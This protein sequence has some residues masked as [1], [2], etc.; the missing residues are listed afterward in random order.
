MEEEMGM[1]LDQ[2]RE[3]RQAGEINLHGTSGD[4]DLSLGPDGRDTVTDHHDH[5]PTVQAGSL[6]I[7]YTFRTEDFGLLGLPGPSSTDLPSETGVQGIGFMVFGVTRD[8]RILTGDVPDHCRGKGGE[9]KKRDSNT[10]VQKG[11]LRKAAAW[12]ASVCKKAAFR[13][14]AAWIAPA[15]RAAFRKRAAWIAPPRRAA[16]RERAARNAPVCKKAAF[17]KSAVL[18]TTDGRTAIGQSVEYHHGSFRDQGWSG[19]GPES[20][21]ESWKAPPQ[22]FRK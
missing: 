7:E 4:L 1:P 10:V 13:K 12:N 16:F 2:P 22:P 9:Q 8:Y 14:R 21:W 15:R 11:A 20:G 17:R 18:K 5:P 19:L 3:K 6:P